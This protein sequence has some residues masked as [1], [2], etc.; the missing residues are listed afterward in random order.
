MAPSGELRSKGRCGVFAR[1]TVWSTPERRRG[2][3]LTTR[4]YTCINL[5]LRLPLHNEWSDFNEIKNNHNKPVT[6]AKEWR[7]YSKQLNGG[8]QVPT[9]TQFNS[10]HNNNN[11]TTPLSLWYYRCVV[12]VTLLWYCCGADWIGRRL[13]LV[14]HRSIERF[15]W[16]PQETKLL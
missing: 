10:H 8:R 1:K 13:A 9:F 12:V 16:S 11:T 14:S 7:T 2:E 5:R 15:L 4:R 6:R 3:V